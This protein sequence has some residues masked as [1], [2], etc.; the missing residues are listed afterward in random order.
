MRRFIYID[1]SS[2]VEGMEKEVARRSRS[3]EAEVAE[4]AAADSIAN[5]QSARA[6][7]EDSDQADLSGEVN[8]DISLDKFAASDGPTRAE[9]EAAN[10]GRL[11]RGEEPVA[12]EAEDVLPEPDPAFEGVEGVGEDTMAARQSH[13]DRV[14]DGEIVR[15]ADNP[16]ITD[17]VQGEPDTLSTTRDAAERA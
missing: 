10:M 1:E 9:V 6:V 17:V 3:E 2:F 16:A 11:A 4:V 14:V 7:A 13:V 12:G 15:A 8:A 5:V